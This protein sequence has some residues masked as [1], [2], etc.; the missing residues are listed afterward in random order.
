V[1]GAASFV[2]FCSRRLAR[3]AVHCIARFF[4]Q[5]T[6]RL[7]RRSLHRS[8]LSLTDALAA[9]PFAASVLSFSRPRLPCRSLHL[10]FLSHA[11]VLPAASLAVSLVSF[12]YRRHVC[13]AAPCISRF[14]LVPTPRLPRRTLHRSIL[15]LH[16]ALAA[17][18]LA[19]SLVSFSCRRVGR[20]AAR[21]ISRFFLL[22]TPRLPRRSLDPSR[23]FLFPTRWP[24]RRSLHRSFLSPADATLAVPLTVSPVFLTGQPLAGGEAR[25]IARFFHLPTCWPPCRSLYRSFLSHADVL[26]AASLAVSLV[27]FAYRRHARR[28]ARCIAWFSRRSISCPRCRSLNRSILSL[29]HALPAAP[30]TV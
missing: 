24:P 25:C 2:S 27:S 4:L 12:A 21:C 17:A 9:A 10:S 29:F 5:P 8:F 14:F 13:R 22:P 20:R 16:D 23:F 15:S 1:P 30:L 19:A 18:P 6:P 11:D 3:R 28:A 7:P 26:P